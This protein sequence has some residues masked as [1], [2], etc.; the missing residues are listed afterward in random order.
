MRGILA[1]GI[2]HNATSGSHPV[3]RAH[4]IKS[5]MQLL[6]ATSDES[7]NTSEEVF[8]LPPNTTATP[9][10]GS[11]AIGH[12]GHALEA[13]STPA[14]ASLRFDFSS[15]VGS[16]DFQTYSDI[17]AEVFDDDNE[18]CSSK[19][20]PYQLY[21]K[22]F[23]DYFEGEF[24]LADVY[25][26]LIYLA[27]KLALDLTEKELTKGIS[28]LNSLTYV[29]E[30]EP[31]TEMPVIH[32][33]LLHAKASLLRNQLDAGL[34]LNALFALAKQRALEIS[35]VYGKRLGGLQPN[36][37]SN[38]LNLVFKFE[39]KHAFYIDKLTFQYRRMAR[40]AARWHQK[41]FINT[42]DR[43]QL[44]ELD[45]KLPKLEPS[46]MCVNPQ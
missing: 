1:K 32:A 40:I 35:N 4:R 37:S 7:E 5:L 13:G 23:N 9:T 38:Y 14:Q 15:E 42:R 30:N 16:E 31:Y 33:Q 2:G 12:K 10:Q 26:A 19:Y 43:S 27:E 22:Y 39:E 46:P 17:G 24:S 45:A 6:Q 28:L 8:D 36:T 44:Q 20:S 29:N 25:P 41:N 34:A 11:D 18:T 3:S 21:S